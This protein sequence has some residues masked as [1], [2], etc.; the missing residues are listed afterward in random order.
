MS[1]SVAMVVKGMDGI[2]VGRCMVEADSPNTV[3]VGTSDAANA[4]GVCT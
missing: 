4:A 2:F 3:L 1:D